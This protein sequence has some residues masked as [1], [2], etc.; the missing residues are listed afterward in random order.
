VETTRLDRQI[1]DQIVGLIDS[2]EF[3]EG[4]RLPPGREVAGLL[5]VSRTSVREAII[6]LEIAGR[7]EVR[8]G[9]G[10]FASRPPRKVHG[11]QAKVSDSGGGPFELLAA[12]A[13][14]EGEVAALAAKQARKADFAALRET[15]V[16]MHDH[17]EN[18]VERDAADRAFDVR[19]AEATGNGALAHA[20]AGLW[21]LR[22]GDLWSR[23]EVHLHTATLRAKT[24]AD[25]EA[26]V[27][28]F[29]A[30][31]PR[32]AQGDASSSRARRARVPAALGRAGRLGRRERLGARPCATE[33][34]TPR[35]SAAGERQ[36]AKAK[37]ATRASGAKPGPEGRVRERGWRP[38]TQSAGFA[39][40]V[41]EAARRRA[42][43]PRRQH[44]ARLSATVRRRG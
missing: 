35:M 8:V 4:S 10:I 36:R 16:W 19:I 40:S 22:R 32:R 39:G 37:E 18:A 41:T 6:A 7:V 27:A 13:L 25:H 34:G 44:S 20:V 30:R 24:L 2:G 38:A 5:G 43:A 26:I 29:A 21:E 23:I 31:D 17:A 9:T 28:A 14:I 1:A 15:I 42:I 33:P 3:P 12:R 11:A